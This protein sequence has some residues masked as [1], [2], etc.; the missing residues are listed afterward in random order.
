[1]KQM[2]QQFAEQ[3]TRENYLA[4]L[5][6]LREAGEPSVTPAEVAALSDKLH[7]SNE[8]A[9]LSAIQ[10]LPKSAAF[11][12][13]VHFLAAEFC[14]RICD[15]QR[16]E[17]ERFLFAACLRGLLATGDGTLARPYVVCQVSD[18]R[19]I[20][21]ALGEVSAELKVLAKGKRTI[22]KHVCLSGREICFDCSQAL[23][24]PVLVA[25][26]DSVEK[27]FA[28]VQLASAAAAVSR[29][30]RPGGGRL[31]AA[32]PEPGIAASRRA[33]PAGK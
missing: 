17:L 28:L 8:A 10:R 6:R 32:R 23:S 4:V 29:K 33:R 15:E 27:P 11:S 2:L 3:P 16:A 24:A 1:M 13:R 22:D 21:L 14:D 26:S 7:A 18:E 9:A 12:P 30:R 5:K 20:L 31:K 25:A 19:D